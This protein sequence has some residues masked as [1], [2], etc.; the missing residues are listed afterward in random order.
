MFAFRADRS[1]KPTLVRTIDQEDA[2]QLL[3]VRD[4]D[5]FYESVPSSITYTSLLH[6]FGLRAPLPTL[7]DVKNEE[8]I[9]HGEW[10]SHCLN[11]WLTERGGLKLNA[12]SRVS[13]VP[14]W[15]HGSRAGNTTC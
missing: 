14:A 6:R 7:H 9:K 15:W 11:I 10:G 4:D 5:P 2:D 8:L 12:I 1:N 3:T 13:F